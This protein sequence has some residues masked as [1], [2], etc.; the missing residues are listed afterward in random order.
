MT[1]FLLPAPTKWNL[2]WW[3]QPL[4]NRRIRRSEGDVEVAS[5]SVPVQAKWREKQCHKN[6]SR[7]SLSA[8]ACSLPRNNIEV[9]HKL[10]KK[11]WLLIRGE[12]YVGKYAQATECKYRLF[13]ILR[14]SSWDGK[15]IN[16]LKIGWVEGDEICPIPKKTLSKKFRK[17]H[18]DQQG[19]NKF[20][21]LPMI[22]PWTSHKNS[23]MHRQGMDRCVEWKLEQG[24][25][26]GYR[27][28]HQRP[29]APKPHHRRHS[30]SRSPTP[31]WKRLIL[32]TKSVL[33]L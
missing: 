28:H 30:G 21:H 5:L 2:F 31:P 23:S 12:V 29:P 4:H 1:L 17:T 18:V 25:R 26:W 24:R 10:A 9:H 3:K 8:T 20:F 14:T 22:N 15:H 16:E 6:Q 7:S 11:I 33:N 19:L 32:F 13:F 27:Y